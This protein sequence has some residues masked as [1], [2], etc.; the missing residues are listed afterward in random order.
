MEVNSV[1]KTLTYRGKSLT[2][3]EEVGLQSPTST[4]VSQNLFKIRKRI[5]FF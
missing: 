3:P 1:T 4:V 2:F 5:L